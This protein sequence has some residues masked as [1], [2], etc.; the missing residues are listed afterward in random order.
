LSAAVFF[1]VAGFFDA[2]VFFVVAGF[3]D[4]AVFF[5]V[6]GFFNVAPFL[7]AAAI[8]GEAVFC[9]GVLPVVFL[10][11]LVAAALSGALA[12]AFRLPTAGGGGS[13]LA[14]VTR[15]VV[16]LAMMASSP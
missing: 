16:A 8:L 2:A 13:A 5:V 1:D 10:G 11:T 15:P 14:G 12:F 6:A 3:F 9:L 7:E 4:A